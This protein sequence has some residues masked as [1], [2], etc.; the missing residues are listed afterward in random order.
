M[1]EANHF[2]AATAA[3]WEEKPERQAL[4]EAILS[5]RVVC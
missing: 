1:T 2:D 5:T 3:T 4:T